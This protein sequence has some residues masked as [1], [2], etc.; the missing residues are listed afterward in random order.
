MNEGAVVNSTFSLAAG[1]D[2]VIRGHVQVVEAGGRKPVLIVCHGFKSFKDWGFFPYITKR[3][4]KS[5]FYVIHFNFSHNGVKV[6]D[7]DELYKFAV[8]TFSREQADLELLLQRLLQGELPHAEQADLS[9]I[10]LL[11]HSRG[12]GNSVLF[13]AAHAEVRAVVT[14][15]GIAD[16]D[17]FDDAFKEEIARSGVAY[18]R[19]ARTQQDMPIAAAFYEDLQANRE[20]FDITRHWVQLQIPMLAVQADHDSP[21]LAQ[22]FEALRQAAPEHSYVIVK[23]ANHTFG[24]IHPFAGTTPQLEAA[25][26]ASLRFLQQRM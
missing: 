12:G 5:G 23:D 24:A 22:G 20:R 26:E 1:E 4:A 11:G 18:T 19:N 3:F 13:A 7:F 6:T 9:R 16:A 8:N 15:N 2:A 14:W 25:I 10:A 21:R 17:L